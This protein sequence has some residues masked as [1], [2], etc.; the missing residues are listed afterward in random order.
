MFL[1][2]ASCF[3]LIDVLPANAIREGEQ[4]NH[5]N[6]NVWKLYKK[7]YYR[8]EKSRKQGIAAWIGIDLGNYNKILFSD[9][10]SA[11]LLYLT[12][13]NQFHNTSV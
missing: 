2:M 1:W 5:K 13:P 7:I 8:E 4:I 9:F 12:T 3:F 10:V 11:N 6:I